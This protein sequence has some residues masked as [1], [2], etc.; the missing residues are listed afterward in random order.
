M[1][2]K[3]RLTSAFKGE[4]VDRVPVLCPGGMMNMITKDLQELTGIKLPEAHEKPDLLAGLAKAVVDEGLFENYGVPF[5]MTGEA[6]DLGAKVDFGSDVFEPH[7]SSYAIKSVDH[8]EQLSPIDF[9]KGRCRTVIDAIK[10]LKD[11]GDRDVPIIGN[12]TGPVSTA[13]SVM[14][15]VPF[16]KELIR[17]KEMSHKYM[18]FITDQLVEFAKLQVEAGA[19]VISISDPTATGELLG[20][21][22]FLEYVP[23]YINQITRAVKDR[24]YTI[25]HI[26]GRMQ[27]A[28]K[29]MDEIEANALSFDSYVPISKAKEVL[30]NRVIMGNISTYSL[31]FMSPDKIKSLTKNTLKNGTNIAA[32][33]CGIGMKSPIEN[34]RAIRQAVEGED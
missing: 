3:E 12:V 9:S 10:V 26:C 8:F 22:L 5:D 16:Y 2:P 24:A 7:V 20:P 17:K 33:A 28:L 23:G 6:Q 31:E 4:K 13:G 18:Q 21:K 15:P 14:D 25:V 34:I 30:P 32:P 19:D 27:P 1:N 29:E 11:I